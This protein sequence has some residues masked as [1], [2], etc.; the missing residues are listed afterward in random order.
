MREKNLDFSG[1]SPGSRIPEGNPGPVPDPGK[2]EKL[3]P[4][5]GQIPGLAIPGTGSR[6]DPVPL[7]IPG[8]DMGEGT[9]VHLLLWSSIPYFWSQI[10]TA[11][12]GRT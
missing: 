12:D 11:F 2:F 7:P 8:Q 1:I 5:P 4:G 9:V 10:Q 3:N 6:F